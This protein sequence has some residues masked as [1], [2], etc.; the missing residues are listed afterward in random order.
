VNSFEDTVAHLLKRL[1]PGDVVLVKASRGMRLE[2]VV[3]ALL[4]R[5]VPPAEPGTA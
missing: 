4:A 1:A 5:L 2:R 3:D